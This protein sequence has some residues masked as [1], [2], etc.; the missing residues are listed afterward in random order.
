MWQGIVDFLGR[1]YQHLVFEIWEGFVSYINI[2]I[3]LK[4]N[5]NKDHMF[6]FNSQSYEILHIHSDVINF[7]TSSIFQCI[8]YMCSVSQYSISILTPADAYEWTGIVWRGSRKRSRRTSWSRRRR[9]LWGRT[10]IQ[11]SHSIK[12]GWKTGSRRKIWNYFT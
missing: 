9:R 7:N 11:R 12:T 6:K 4:K 8:H 5:K 2:H 1:L 3:N 10:G